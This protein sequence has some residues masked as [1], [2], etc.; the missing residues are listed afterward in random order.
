MTTPPPPPPP[1]PGP[2][3]EYSGD[4]LY[5]PTSDDDKNIALIAHVGNVVAGVI[6]PLIVMLIKKDSPFIQQESKEALNFSILMFL[7]S[8]VTC[9]IAWFVAIVFFII[10]AIKV[11]E[12]QPYRYPFNVRLIK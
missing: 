11:S 10:A 4:G 6:A 5:R 8:I 7:L 9:G 1:S 2:M 12:G 3:P